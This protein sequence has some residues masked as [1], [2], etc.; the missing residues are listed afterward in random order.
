[1]GFFS[2]VLIVI[3]LLAAIFL[4]VLVLMQRSK[5]QGLGTAFGGGM[6]DTMFGART[7]SVL[8]KATIWCAVLLFATTLGLAI[9]QRQQ[10]RSRSLLEKTLQERA[11][12]TAPTTPSAPETP[13]L[14]AT[15]TP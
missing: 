11:I 4:I 15:P 1:M 5:D 14:P 13:S 7:S 8:V 9:A 2:G 12:P 6:T 10:G 3:H